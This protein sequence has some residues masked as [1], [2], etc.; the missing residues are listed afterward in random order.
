[1]QDHFGPQAIQNELWFA[2]VLAAKSVADERSRNKLAFCKQVRD[3]TIASHPLL[4]D[5]KAQECDATQMR[6]VQKLVSVS[7]SIS[8]PW[9]G[10]HSYGA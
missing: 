2:A 3:E 6:I 7:I 4:T 5:S 8:T 10:V 1:M 9:K